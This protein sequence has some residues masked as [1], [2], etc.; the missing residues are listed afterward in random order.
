MSAEATREDALAAVRKILDTE[1]CVY[2]VVGLVDELHRQAGTWDTSSFLEYPVRPGAPELPGRRFW[3]TA[4]PFKDVV[5]VCPSWC[6]T[7]PHRFEMTDDRNR[8]VVFHSVEFPTVKDVVLCVEQ[9]AVAIDAS[10]DIYLG[11]PRVAMY[12][13]NP[14]E[15][16]MDEKQT[17]QFSA[18]L[19]K[20]ATLLA[21]AVPEWND[22]TEAP[23]R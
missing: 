7:G 4:E 20:A 9:K 22:M 3:A 12:V 6:K 15:I 10:K 1:A 17:R 5:E 18:S 8:P 13:D 19:D 11:R 2:D 14:G 23:Q 16:H 21:A